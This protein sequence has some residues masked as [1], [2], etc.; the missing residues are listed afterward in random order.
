MELVKHEMEQ[1]ITLEVPLIAE[2][3][4][5]TSWLEAH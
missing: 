5:G 1:V 2:V 4:V 3:G